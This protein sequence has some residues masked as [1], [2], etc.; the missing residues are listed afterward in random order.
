MWDAAQEVHMRERDHARLLADL[1]EA[2]TLHAPASGALN[3][4]AN[5]WLVDGGVVNNLPMDVVHHG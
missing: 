3:E 2:Y 1:H 4:R 5:R